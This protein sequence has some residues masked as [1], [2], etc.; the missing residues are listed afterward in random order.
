M[1]LKKVIYGFILFIVSF[2]ISLFYNLPTE[3]LFL[4]LL[5]ELEAKS[6]VYLVYSVGKFSFNKIDIS[7]VDIYKKKENLFSLERLLIKVGLF[8][9][10]VYAYKG[11]GTLKAQIKRDRSVINLNNFE[12]VSNGS[13]YFKKVSVTGSFVL[14]NKRLSGRGKLR[15]FLKE[16]LD[17]MLKTDLQA[18]GTVL[19][20]PSPHQITFDI[21]SI[22]GVNIQGSGTVV[23]SINEKNFGNSLLRGNIR[24]ENNGTRLSLNLSG[25]VDKPNIVPSFQ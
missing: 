4:Y 20:S 25:T 16:S 10:D 14:D 15:L 2:C 22:S 7:D 21:Q 5:N 24:V 11:V 9:L 12:I 19:L 13:K 18:E 17:P 3:G 23:I 1:F 8:N 6:G